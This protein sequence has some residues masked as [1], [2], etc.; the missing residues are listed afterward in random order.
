VPRYVRK[1]RGESKDKQAPQFLSSWP[2]EEA[3]DREGRRGK[4]RGG[5]GETLKREKEKRD[6]FPY[7]FFPD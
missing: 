4:T 2:L 6:Q 3:Q 7:R 5:G 1:N